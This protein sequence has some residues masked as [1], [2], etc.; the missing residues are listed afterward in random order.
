VAPGSA[1]QSEAWWVPPS[2]TPS[3]AP[4]AEVPLSR[5][6]HPAVAVAAGLSLLVVAGLLAVLALPARPPAP[7]EEPPSEP[8][9]NLVQAPGPGEQPE[10]LHAP[11]PVEPDEDATLTP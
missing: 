3:P 11:Q 1:S 6:V 4:P 10:R 5:K 7:V 8:P 9:V 2:P